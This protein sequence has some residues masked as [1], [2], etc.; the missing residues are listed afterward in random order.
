VLNVGTRAARLS[1][2]HFQNRLRPVFLCFFGKEKINAP[3]FVPYFILQAL[4]A[5]KTLGLCTTAFPRKPPGLAGFFMS[6][7]FPAKSI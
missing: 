2:P 7:A 3:Y 4:Q 5:L 6:Q 1:G